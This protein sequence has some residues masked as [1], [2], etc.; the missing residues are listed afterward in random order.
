[1]TA[2]PNMHPELLG[3]LQAIK[4]RHWWYR[5]RRTVLRAVLSPHQRSIPSGPI[6]DLGSGPGT[7]RDL[8]GPLD[9]P[10]F[11]LDSSVEA[12]RAC[13]DARYAAGTLADAVAVPF[14]DRTF[15]L[16]LAADI[17]EHVADDPTT[18]AEI[19]RV[20]KPGGLA[21]V[22]V[23]AFDSLW[24][25]QDQVS[26]HYRRYSPAAIRKLL[27]N[28][29]FDVVRTTCLN[30]LLALPILAV[31]RLLRL[32]NFAA[33]SENQILPNLLNPIMYAIFAAEA[34]IVSRWDMP[35]GT[36]VVCLARRQL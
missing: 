2:Q 30:T 27:R 4:S 28:S 13:Q 7:N 33:R 10:L 29:G 9:R 24:G 19:F 3:E 1:M 18:A 21:L 6:L 22:V 16:V 5:G 31:R 17:L 36:S 26:G 23:P 11:A 20:L 32:T 14:R 15:A 12:L 34:P 8:L 25:W 35:Y